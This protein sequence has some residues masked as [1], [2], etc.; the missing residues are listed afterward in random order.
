MS[1]HASVPARMPSPHVVAQ[2]DGIVPMHVQPTSRTQVA[3]QP[4]PS[5]AGGAS[6]HISPGITRPSPQTGVHVDGEPLHM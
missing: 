6:S 2:I 3:E 5:S 1:S 4:S